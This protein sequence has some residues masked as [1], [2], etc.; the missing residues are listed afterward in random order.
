[1]AAITEEMVR[2][3]YEIGVKVYRGEMTHTDAKAEVNHRTGMDFGS[4]GDYINVLQY[5]L[6]GQVYKR[7]INKYAT[8]Y[9]LVHIGEDFGRDKQRLAASAASAHVQY[10]RSIHG[11]LASIDELARRYK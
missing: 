1:M 8:E 6:D 11:Y 7:T 2:C 5:M 3:A 10:Y 9:Y 4:A